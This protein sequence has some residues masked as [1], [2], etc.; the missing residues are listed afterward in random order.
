VLRFFDE[1]K[2]CAAL[3]H[4]EQARIV[5]LLVERSTCRRARS[6]SNS[7]ASAVNGYKAIP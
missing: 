4:A 1:E 6:R 5:Q 3:C 7:T 2:R